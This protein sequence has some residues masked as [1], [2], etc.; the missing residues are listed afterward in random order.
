MLIDWVLLIHHSRD[1]LAWVSLHYV[2]LFLEDRGQCWSSRFSCSTHVLIEISK[3]MNVWHNKN[4][5]SHMSISISTFHW[6]N[7]IICNQIMNKLIE[8]LYVPLHKQECEDRRSADIPFGYL[9]S[10]LH[11]SKSENENMNVGREREKK[12][13][14][15]MDDG[16]CFWWSVEICCTDCV[17]GR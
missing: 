17:A 2:H 16:E 5:L 13:H 3:I 15:S 14:P 9:T 6:S 11:L 8:W 4:V 7:V 12:N 10:H 1:M